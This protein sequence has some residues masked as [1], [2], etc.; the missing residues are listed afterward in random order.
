[1]EGRSAVEAPSRRSAASIAPPA[2]PA[3]DD[4]N[5]GRPALGETVRPPSGGTR[6]ELLATSLDDL[7]TTVVR[8]GVRSAVGAPSFEES[9]RR[10]VSAAPAPL[11]ASLARVLARLVEALGVADIGLVAQLC[12]GLVRLADALRHRDTLLLGAWLGTGGASWVDTDRGHPSFDGPRP[13]P[14]A[15]LVEVRLVEVAREWVPTLDRSGLERRYLVAPALGRVYREERLRTQSAP[16]L[17]PCPRVLDVALA[18]VEPGPA[19]QRL[20][21]LQY[22]VSLVDAP[23]ALAGV[24]ALGNASFSEVIRDF[25]SDLGAFPALVEPFALLAPSAIERTRSG[26]VLVDATGER[27]ALSAE[28]AGVGEL[29]TALSAAAVPPLVCGRLVVDRGVVALAALAAVVRVG[30]THRLRRFA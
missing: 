8:A 2:S 16:S 30:A 25:S 13:D 23:E 4:S 3:A 28:P 9:I 27:L 12:H 19:P 21:L 14:A 11:P 17:G 18:E 29:L 26:T 22:E 15:R 1:M 5:V 7:V 10:V 6:A 24:T 20:H